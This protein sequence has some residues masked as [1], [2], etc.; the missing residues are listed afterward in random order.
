M[1]NIITTE[2][3]QQ[4]ELPSEVREQPT[5]KTSIYHQ[6]ELVYDGATGQHVGSASTAPPEPTL[7]GMLKWGIENSSPEE[8]A[9]LKAEGRAPPSEL[10]KQIMDH[11]LG[12]PTVA[13]MRECL[14][15][16]TPEALGAADGLEAGE[17]ALE[18]LEFYAEGIDDALDLCKINGLP[19]LKACCTYGLPASTPSSD[20]ASEA[21]DAAAA[22]AAVED[23]DGCSALRV[24]AC[25]VLAAMMQNNPKVQ[26]AARAS[27]VAEV[28][29]RLLGGSDAVDGWEER[30][31]GLAVVRKANYALSAMVRANV[32]DS[33]EADVRAEAEAT[34]RLALPRLSALAGHSDAKVRQR[35]LFALAALTDSPISAAVIW[36]YAS[37]DGSPL[38]PALATALRSE[39][40]DT[41]VPCERLLLNARA[42]S[43]APL[44]AALQA[45]GGAAAANAAVAVVAAAGADGNADEAPRLQ[46]ILAWLA[47]A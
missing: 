29:L 28:L 40:E 46:Q 13:K 4:Q 24:A 27:E 22:T 18:E 3:G 35:T 26:Q 47:T 34:L 36:D 43:V 44:R 30:V 21:T 2:G 8:L 23:P 33:T 41:R 32:S 15:K 39:S 11:I 7:N 10:D 1:P 19:V 31:G 45:A 42:A 38:A 5:S 20:G 14:G 6:G 12:Q 37:A 17:A 16:L 25:G 9:R